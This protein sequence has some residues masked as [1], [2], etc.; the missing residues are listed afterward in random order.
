M[1]NACHKAGELER[2]ESLRRGT[3]WWNPLK[4]TLPDH[5]DVLQPENV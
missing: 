5:L 2:N 4:S 1:G 3:H